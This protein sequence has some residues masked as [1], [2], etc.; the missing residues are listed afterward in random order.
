MLLTDVIMP[1]ESRCELGER[2]LKIMP[3]L[4][5][6]YMTGYDDNAIAHHVLTGPEVRFLH[7][8][9]TLDSLLQGVHNAIHEPSVTRN[10][11]FD[12]D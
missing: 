7:K 12:N 10:P 3:K 4:K 1:G 11:L 9:F 8:P 2:L 6:L 5:L